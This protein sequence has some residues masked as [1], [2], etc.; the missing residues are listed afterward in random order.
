MEQSA[1]A[2]IVPVLAAAPAPVEVLPADPQR[3]AACLAALGMTTRSWLGAVVSNAGGLVADHGW[4]R[5]LGCGYDGLPDVVAATDIETGRLVV[6][7]DVM[8][9][10]FAWFKAGP[11]ATPTVHYFGPDELSWQDLGLGYG[12]WLEAMLTASP[13]E[14]YDTMRWP[15]WETEIAAL[16]LDQGISTMPPLWTKEGKDVSRTSRRAIPLAELVSVHHDV[17]RQLG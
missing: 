2:E 4:L 5:V 12:D 11:D 16:A 7:Y 13:A 17:A 8:G 6:A 9:G 14:F 10:Q 15:G 3:A 1:W